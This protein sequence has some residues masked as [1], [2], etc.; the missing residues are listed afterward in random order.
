MSDPVASNDTRIRAAAIATPLL[1]R[2]E[3]YELARA[4]R[5]DRDYD[6]RERL[7]VAHQKLVIGTARKYCRNNVAFQ[8]LVNEGNLGLIEAAER[9][10]PEKGNR[11]A[12]YAAFWVLTYI[13]DF[14]LHNLTPVRIGRS[15]RERGALRKLSGRMSQEDFEACADIHDVDAV[16]LAQMRGALQPMSLSMGGEEGEPDLSS[17][18]EDPSTGEAKIMDDV[19]AERMLS[20]VREH[21][22]QLK[23]RERLVIEGRHLKEPKLMLGAIAEELGVS[24]ERVRQIEMRAL[25]KLKRSIS[26]AGFEA[27]DL[28]SQHA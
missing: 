20:V 18:I 22:G 10:E 25:G 1:T 19:T 21:L 9:F 3:E 23:P 28:L 11:F 6:A 16:D 14:M 7:I 27:Q 4:W 15:R 17:L 24:S 8:D 2:E 26:R 12:T 13:Q 5:E